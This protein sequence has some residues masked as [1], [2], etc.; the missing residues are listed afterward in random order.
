MLLAK[1]KEYTRLDSLALKRQGSGTD[2]LFD[3]FFSAGGGSSFGGQLSEARVFL[4]SVRDYLSAEI[5]VVP[6]GKH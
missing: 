5:S 2:A 4:A 6:L 1:Y 3:L